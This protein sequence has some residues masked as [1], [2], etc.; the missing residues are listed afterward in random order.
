MDEYGNSTLVG[1]REAKVG[2]IYLGYEDTE[3]SLNNAQNKTNA[4]IRK[5]GIFLYEDGFGSITFLKK[6]LYS[7]AFGNFLNTMLHPISLECT[8]GIL[9]R[10]PAP[11]S[12]R[13]HEHM[14]YAP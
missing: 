5:T 4:V 8:Y 2:A 14:V 12:L 6:Q 10:F 1:I 3:F 9:L 7:A 13:L 11:Y